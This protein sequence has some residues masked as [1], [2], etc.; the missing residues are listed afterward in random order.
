MVL[1][2]RIFALALN[3][4]IGKMCNNKN[5]ELSPYYKKAKELLNYNPDTGV[6]TWKVSKRGVKFGA[7][8]GTISSHGYVRIK[9]AG[10]ILS[11]HRL[12]WYF[13]HNEFPNI[14]DHI[15][16]VKDDNR[17]INLRS[18][19]QAENMRNTG[20]QNNNTSGYKGVS[21]SNEKRK[22]RVQIYTNNKNKHLGYFDSAKEASEAYE[23]KTK[24][25]YGEFYHAEKKDR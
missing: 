3:V 13:I 7:K 15:N 14:I 17:I 25:L 19:T 2:Q 1:D 10:K 18:C 12:A 21:W 24:E 22:W 23:A 9:V 8:A 4:R 11:S 16:G 5:K 20:K 6:F